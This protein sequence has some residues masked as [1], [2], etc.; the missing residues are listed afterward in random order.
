[1]TTAATAPA[2]RNKSLAR[3]FTGTRIARILLVLIA[4]I[5]A[6]AVRPASVNAQSGNATIKS[7]AS[8]PFSFFNTCTGE[9]VSG[10]VNVKTTVHVSPDGNGG[11][12]AHLHE[13]FNGRAVGETSGIQYVGPQTDHESFN[14]SSGGLVEDTFTLDFR[15]L[16][17]GDADN[18]LVHTL[19]H[20][21]VSPDGEV[22]AEVDAVT[23][24]CKG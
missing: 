2:A 14:N 10:V 17:R 6:T 7:S 8:F 5:A 16:S 11:F 9:V 22:K 23:D 12:H 15:F 3:I 24:E 4:L 20:I 18:I 21:T 13:V 1:M 19:F